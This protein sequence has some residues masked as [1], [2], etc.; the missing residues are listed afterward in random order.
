VTRRRVELAATAAV[1]VA[2]LVVLLGSGGGALSPPP[3]G[4]P[5]RWS[6]WLDHREPTAAAF[7]L[8]RV[9]ALAAACYLAGV[10]ILG[11][12]LR[13]ARAVRLVALADR[14]TVPPVRR[15]LAGTVTA[16]LVGLG[17]VG[18]VAAQPA[19]ST[20]PTT[21]VATSSTP[22][23]AVSTRSTSTTALATSDDTVVLHRL[24]AGTTPPTA[25]PTA[26]GN[27]PAT[28]ATPAERPPATWTVKAGDCFWSIAEDVLQQAW[29]RAPTDAEIVPYWR[30]LIDANRQALADKGN[31][32][33]IFPG[34]MFAVPP[35][36]SA[37]LARTG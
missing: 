10:T 7:A 29:G 33:L 34:Q 19:P 25:V 26:T 32:D 21:A 8:L 23:T 3:L 24:P 35:A 5:D 4:S 16:G 15:F 22:T 2:T 12:A 17:P 6:A 14:F 9:G 28:P 27:T 31:A 30:A 20:T 18:A 13:S 37:P 36:P 1:M 11:V